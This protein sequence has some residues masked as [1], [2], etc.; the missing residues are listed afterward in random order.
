MD[1]ALSQTPLQNRDPE[2]AGNAFFDLT[3][4]LLLVLDPRG[5]VARANPALARIYGRTPDEL[6]GAS[7]G[8]L[9]QPEDREA[10]ERRLRDL[11]EDR[12]PDTSLEH[13]LAGREG[14]RWV[15]WRFLR[16]PASGCILGS[17]RE[18]HDHI[19]SLSTLKQHDH[20]R[21]LARHLPECDTFLF[22][23]DLMILLAEGTELQRYGVIHDGLTG[24][25]VVEVFPRRL[26]R[27]IVPLCRAALDGERLSRELRFNERHYLVHT[28]PL[29][30]ERGEIYGGMALSIN[31]T[32]LKNNETALRLS[33]AATEMARE[34]LAR[35]HREKSL[36]LKKLEEQAALL[37]LQ[38]KQDDLTGV[39]NRRYLN[40][41]LKEEFQRSVRY[42]R[43]LTVAM[44]DVDH[45]KKIN[46]RFLHSTG[47]KALI[48]VAEILTAA[49]R[50]VDCVAR[51][52]GEE[53]TLIFPETTGAQAALIAEKIRQ[54]VQDYDWSSIHPDLAVTVSIG[55]AERAGQK[56]PDEL[57]IA[58]DRNLYQAKTGG[59]NQICLR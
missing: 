14:P 19:E 49:V 55:V 51:F 24:Q 33:L 12:R 16:D 56:T 32:Q 47:D 27:Q 9:V 8:E 29:V 1:G 57:L 44:C 17:A 22:D 48:R 46:D 42:D 10:S 45:F 35:A 52:G 43:A 40:N 26:S 59:R 28:L 38:N 53:F 36:L 21:T 11:F 58:A 31:I 50:K 7:F 30:N 41:R 37:E 6:V 13:R 5:R 15:S 20:Y 54:L 3:P 23:R 2:S 34:E 18:I 25:R 4:D 39:F